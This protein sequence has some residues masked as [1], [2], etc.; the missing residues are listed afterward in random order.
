MMYHAYIAIVLE[1]CS[2]L[3]GY[4]RKFNPGGRGYR[5]CPNPVGTSGYV[6]ILWGH[7]KV[8]LLEN[9][10]TNDEGNRYL[11]KISGKLP[12]EMLLLCGTICACFHNWIPGIQEVS[13][14]LDDDD[15]R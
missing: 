4:L 2:F 15:V 1:K 11:E 12:R 5:I 10:P 3:P 8:I 6:W 9:I 14:V 7:W 13:I